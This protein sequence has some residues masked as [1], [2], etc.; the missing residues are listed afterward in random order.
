MT[1]TI[2]KKGNKDFWH[3]WRTFKYA[4]NDTII[5]FDNDDGI[6]GNTVKLRSMQGRVVFKQDGFLFSDVTIYDDSQGGG[7]ETFT[8]IEALKSRLIN[9]GYPFNGGSDEIVLT[10]VEWAN[11]I[12]DI[13]L[14]TQLINYLSELDVNGGTP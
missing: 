4:A 14:N 8:S 7:A 9:L 11:I 2:R 5:I 10:E 12:G 6:T 13:E 3:Y 1:L